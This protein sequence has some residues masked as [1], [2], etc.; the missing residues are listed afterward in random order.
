MMELE[1][2]NNK[3]T[4]LLSKLSSIDAEIL[5]FGVIV[6]LREGL[7]WCRNHLYYGFQFGF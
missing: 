1:L 4:V 7:T 2:D 6:P 3:N 5:I